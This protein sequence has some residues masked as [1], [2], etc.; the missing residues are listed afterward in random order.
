MH[1]QT[2]TESCAIF[3]SS[4]AFA[5]LV[6]SN[7]PYRIVI[8]WEAVIFGP[9]PLHHCHHLIVIRAIPPSISRRHPLISTCQHLSLVNILQSIIVIM[10]INRYLMCH[11]R[12]WPIR[13][14]KCSPIT[15]LSIHMPRQHR[16]MPQ[17]SII[18][19]LTICRIRIPI[20][21]FSRCIRRA[22]SRFHLPAAISRRH[23]WTRKLNI[24]ARYHSGTRRWSKCA[25]TTVRRR[26]RVGVLHHPGTDANL[27]FSL[28]SVQK[29]ELREKRCPF[30]SHIS[31]EL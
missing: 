31:I 29:K 15:I 12:T 9:L 13:I 25:V 2:G 23:R 3:E 22:T 17:R 30:S 14:L 6:F 26:T 18:L 21:I 20:H 8:W 10:I 19:R 28:L 7:R 5:D 11:R 27:S 1:H 24:N 4:H 16:T